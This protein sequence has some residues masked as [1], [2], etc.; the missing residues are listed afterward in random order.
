MLGMDCAIRRHQTCQLNSKGIALSSASFEHG[1]TAL[2]E[3]TELSYNGCS[4]SGHRLNLRPTHEFRN[5]N[6]ARQHLENASEA[7]LN[8]PTQCQATA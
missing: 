8:F 1:I 6:S 3:T 2:G 5:L 7:S 4:A